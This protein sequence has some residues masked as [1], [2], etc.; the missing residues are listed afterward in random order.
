MISE[1]PWEQFVAS[2]LLGSITSALAYLVIISAGRLVRSGTGRSTPPPDDDPRTVKVM[3]LGLEGSGKTMMLAG[4]YHRWAYGDRRGVVLRA[5]VMTTTFL[6]RI[7]HRINN[8]DSGLPGS[9]REGDITKAIFTFFVD[10][11]GHN[12]HPSFSLQYIDYAGERLRK[13]LLPQEGP[14][15][16]Q[17]A[18][19]L[20]AADVLVG[21][22][23]GGHIALAMRGEPPPEFAGTL[24]DLIRCLANATQKTTHVVISK[25]DLVV[26]E[27]GQSIPLARVIRF[28]DQYPPFRHY[29]ERPPTV[30]TR[31]I[32]PISAFGLNGFIK[33]DEN[34]MVHK[35]RAV[36]WQPFMAEHAVACSVPDVINT[37]L[38]CAIEATARNA[39]GRIP[40]RSLA[41]LLKVVLSV[42][43]AVTG[44][45]TGFRIFTTMG[46]SYDEL[47]D[48]W[49][50]LRDGPR[51]DTART[52]SPQPAVILRVLQLFR[53]S[54]RELE[55]RFPDS[56]IGR[57]HPP[58]QNR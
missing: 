36:T 44:Q 32:I 34:G 15:D 12:P 14:P 2:L 16:A 24:T 19:D 11:A 5:D 9:T 31:R 30:G 35:N 43:S 21:I 49:H 33:V 40:T 56:E 4:M 55:N 41:P 23:D 57:Y 28:L 54:V 18:A 7:V 39:S 1:F 42:L 6:A 53:D 22:L 46:V 52:H 20:A 37:Q 50:A 3:V 13:V 51:V 10:V 17:V 58:P 26:D 45:W 29:R 25:W 8:A 48:A 47:V 38:E 27:N